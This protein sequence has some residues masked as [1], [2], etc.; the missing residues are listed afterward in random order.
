MSIFG[1]Q[2]GKC[3]RFEKV[4]GG[5]EKKSFEKKSFEKKKKKKKKKKK[6]TIE[7]V[8]RWH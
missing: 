7:M 2:E 4:V 5:I 6:E 1:Y 3:K 8:L